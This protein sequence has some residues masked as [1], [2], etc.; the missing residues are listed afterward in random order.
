M[1]AR[2]ADVLRLVLQQGVALVAIG[3]MIGLVV[4]LALTR[5]LKRVILLAS[6]TD[7]LTFAGIT[8]LLTAV[9]LGAC[10]LPAWRAM[11]VDPMNALRH[12]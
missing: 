4:T 3:I 8:L 2:P 5:I 7:P 12:E 10:Y 6:A 11:R 1:G 9:A